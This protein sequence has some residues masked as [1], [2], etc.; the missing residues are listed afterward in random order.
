MKLVKKEFTK[1]VMKITSSLYKVVSLYR[2]TIPGNGAILIRVK[3]QSGYLIKNIYK[4]YD[5]ILA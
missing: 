2:G 4:T 3:I 1:L 5:L